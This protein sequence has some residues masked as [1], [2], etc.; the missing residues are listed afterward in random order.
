VKDKQLGAVL[1]DLR[2]IYG[3][4]IVVET[5]AKVQLKAAITEQLLNVP[6]DTALELIAGQ[7]DLGVVRKGNTFRL[8]SNPKG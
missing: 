4:N 7:A 1:D 3:V 6:A 8:I 5:G 2:C